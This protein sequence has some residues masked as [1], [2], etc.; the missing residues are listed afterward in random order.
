MQTIETER[1]RTDLRQF[2]V[3][4]FNYHSAALGGQSGR[5]VRPVGPAFRNIS[6]E[7]FDTEAQHYFLAEAAVFAA[8]MVTAA[9]PL[10]NG[11]HAVLNL[12][13]LFGAV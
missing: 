3:T 1:S 7:Y 9:W 5:C 13:G 8:I 12:V 2:P 11:A 4:D 6:R 10:V